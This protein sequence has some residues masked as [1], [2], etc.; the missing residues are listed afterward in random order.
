MGPNSMR[1]RMFCVTFFI[2]F[3]VVMMITLM[4][5]NSSFGI[6]EEF[7]KGKVQGG[8]GTTQKHNVT[9]VLF[10]GGS[11]VQT[12]HFGMV[13]NVQNTTHENHGRKE[14]NN[15][16]VKNQR[17]ASLSS[18]NN[19]SVHTV[20]HDDKDKLLG[21]LIAPG[22][23]EASCISKVQSHIYRKTS[24]QKP[25]PYLISKLRGYEKIHRMCGPKSKAYNRHMIRILH[26]KNNSATTMCKYLIWTPANGLGNQMISLAATFL[27][28]ILTDRVLLV[29]FGKDIHGL[30]CEP[31]V[32][33]TWIL[34]KK[35]PFW[36][37]EHIETYQKM[38]EID[39]T[40][41]SKEGLPSAL[42]IN[43]Q[44][45][46]R[47][48]EKFF[49]CDHN[50]ELLNKIPLLILLSDQYF[51]PSLFMTPLFNMEITKMFPE[52]DTIFHHLGR[53]LFNP[54]NEAWR[55]I[56]KFYDTYLAKANEITGL[57]I[58]VFKPHSTPHQAIMNLVLNCTLTHKLLP[59]IALK[60]PVSSTGKN[61]PI[62]SVLVASLYPE[63]GDTLRTMYLKKPTVTGEVIKVYQAS[64][65]EHQ[66]FYD[67][68]HN[69]KAWVD[70]YLLSLSDK[71]VTT[72][73]STFGYVANGLGHLR[74]WLLYR[75]V[76]NGTHFPSCV[77]DVSMEPCFH[78]PPKHFCN[79]KPIENHISSF[80]Y[81][82][83]CQ[84]VPWGVQIV[85]NGSI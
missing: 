55:I 85:N 64:H 65:E 11:N 21:G 44:Y 9:A 2:A 25:S 82:R 68:K 59:E 73:Q 23:D 84:D 10:T 41:N 28:A 29:R 26:S 72:S 33:S 43:L 56:S 78:N 81:L 20:N 1:L 4:H 7:S 15:D 27:Y 45:T 75:L 66:K 79:G 80:L 32:N 77:R 39:M 31:F 17:N 47:G 63:Y 60:N 51:V 16:P 36:N 67:N 19:S 14:E 34:P 48:P 50:Q 71:L 37:D 40:K 42:F 54:S 69:M 74:P 8:G 62:N 70:M 30:F 6:F 83:E 22:F 53:Y 18:T 13:G 3:P 12:N 46:P 49:H 5:R 38:L 35:S 76:K 58:R 24:P 57:Q 52:K 61:H